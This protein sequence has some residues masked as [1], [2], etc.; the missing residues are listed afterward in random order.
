MWRIQAL[1][2]P[3]LKQDPNLGWGV[4]PSY[5]FSVE[6]EEKISPQT[7]MALY[8]DHYEGTPYDM[9][10]GLAGGPF[11]NPARY[12]G[13]NKGV[14][15][16]WER[17]VS[18]FRTTFSFICNP[19]PSLPDAL[20]VFWFGLG[21][22]HGTVYVPIYANQHSLP[23]SYATGKQSE[24]SFDCAWWAF[25]FVNNWIQLR[26]DAMI[27]EV[28]AK[29]NALERQGFELQTKFEEVAYHKAQG[30]TNREALQVLY[31]AASRHADHVVST[32][33]T[34]AFQLVGKYID[35]YVTVGEGS[36]DRQQPGYPAWWLAATNFK[37]DTS[38]TPQW[39]QRSQN[40][41]AAVVGEELAAPS[42]GPSTTR[43]LMVSLLAILGLGLFGVGWQK[44]HTP[45]FQYQ[46]I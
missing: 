9:T 14:T 18:M 10:T 32:W 31:D 17:Q 21:T 12:D 20:G 2:A 37:H 41:Q 44:A 23:A 16:D 1:V 25:A 27:V 26:Y 33:W 28:R 40:T 42:A 30:K 7:I 43:W 38:P 34:F 6:V 35:G 29:Q 45:E 3:S 22:P 39:A 11:G 36:G 15:G 5:P 46:S 13:D 8:R 24:F 19:R 4:G